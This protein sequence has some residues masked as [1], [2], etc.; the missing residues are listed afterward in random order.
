MARRGGEILMQDSIAA[1]HRGN[2]SRRD[3]YN[4][5]S[6]HIEASN[7]GSYQPKILISTHSAR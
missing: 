2:L 6:D 3:I 4:Y 7:L 1:I 5:R